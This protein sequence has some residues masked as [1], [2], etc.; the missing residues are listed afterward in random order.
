MRGKQLNKIVIRKDQGL[1]NE[2]E[3]GIRGEQS[4]K[5]EMKFEWGGKVV[6]PTVSR[7]VQMAA[8]KNM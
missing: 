3:D 5:L 4:L 7:S 8:T 6:L 2:D 1:T